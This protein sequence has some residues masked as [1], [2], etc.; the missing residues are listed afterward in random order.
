MK[1]SFFL[2]LQTFSQDFGMPLRRPAWADHKKQCHSRSGLTD[3]D[4][5]SSASLNV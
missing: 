5:I 2:C 3:W 4:A 1:P